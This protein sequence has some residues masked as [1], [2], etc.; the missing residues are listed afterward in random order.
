MEASGS[1]GSKNAALPVMAAALLSTGTSVLRGCPRISDVYLMEKIL[2]IWG[3]K[4]GGR[5]RSLSGLQPCGRHH[6]TGVLFR[7]NAFFRDLNGSNAGAEQKGTDRISRRLCDREAAGG[8]SYPGFAPPWCSCGGKRR[9]D[10]GI[11]WKTPRRRDVF[12]KKK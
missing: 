5:S 8:S 12:S 7:K 6:D 9:N 3:Q 2:N 1:R 10:P 11:L 4:P